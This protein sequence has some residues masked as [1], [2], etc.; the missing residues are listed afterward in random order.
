MNKVTMGAIWKAWFCNREQKTPILLQDKT[1]QSIHTPGHD[2]QVSNRD[3]HK[4]NGKTTVP[5]NS[6]RQK[7]DMN[8]LEV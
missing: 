7:N 8:R 2:I 6:E 1:F 3:F 5:Q 4:I